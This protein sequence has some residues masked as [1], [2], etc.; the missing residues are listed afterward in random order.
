MNDEI[1]GGCLFQEEVVNAVLLF[2]LDLFGLAL[3]RSG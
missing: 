3:I 2:P 1:L